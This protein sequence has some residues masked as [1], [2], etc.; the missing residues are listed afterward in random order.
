M[1][2]LSRSA[3]PH[4]RPR[5]EALVSEPLLIFL[6][7]LVLYGAYRWGYHRGWKAAQSDIT[8]DTY[9]SWRAHSDKKPNRPFS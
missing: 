2:R 9:E 3:P 8:L 4:P 5:V 7:T 6:G 1:D